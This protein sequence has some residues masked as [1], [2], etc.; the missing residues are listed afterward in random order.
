M[1]WN[2]EEDAL[3]EH[4]QSPVLD[5]IYNIN[6]STL[7]VDYHSAIA[8]ALIK[9]FDWWADE[10]ELSFYLMLAGEEG[11]GWFQEDNPQAVLYFSRRCKLVVRTPIALLDTVLSM[12]GL[13]LLVEQHEVNIIHK[14]N[15]NL[16]FSPTLYARH[17]VSNLDEMQF[18]ETVQQQLTDMR[19]NCKKML[20]GKSRLLN[21]SFGSL[22]TRSLMLNNLNKEDSLRL[23]QQGLGNYKKYGCGVFVPYKSITETG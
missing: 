19:I 18:L 12:S 1:F 15:R 4:Q 5:V 16:S 6:G 23:Q 17:V 11:N 21:T 7:P 20:C 13:K 10:K 2:D 14:H 9:T 22:P 3:V 8:S